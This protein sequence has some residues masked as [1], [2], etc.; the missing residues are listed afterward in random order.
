MEEWLDF[1]C[2]SLKLCPSQ[3][4]EMVLVGALCFSNLFMHREDLKCSIMHHPLWQQTFP[5]DMLIFDI[6][7]SDFLANQKKTKMLFVSAER[8]KQEIIIDFFKILYDG[9]PKQYPQGSMMLFIPLTESSHYSMEYRSK[10]MFNHDKFNGDEAAVCIG[11][12]KDLKTLIK[13]KNGS[14]VSLQTLLKGFPASQ[15][16][17]RSL[18]FQH[19]EP[20]A[21]RVVAMAT[22][23]KT[24]QFYIDKRKSTLESEIRQVIADGEASNVF[25]DKSEGMWFGSVFKNK[26]G[27]VISSQPPTRAGIDYVN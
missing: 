7:V 23:Q 2:Y 17:S 3:A 25:Q 11:G 20:N 6:Y 26:G 18:L 19:I 13:L 4:E 12:L 9:E 14:I 1:H 21:T 8:S 24:Y 16:M 15:G 5:E 27:R 22:Y 10:I